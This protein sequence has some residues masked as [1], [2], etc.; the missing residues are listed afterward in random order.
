MILDTLSHELDI[1]DQW[2]GL[3]RLRQDY[4]PTPY[5]RKTPDHQHIPLLSITESAADYLADSHWAMPELPD[6]PPRTSPLTE[7]ALEYD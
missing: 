7:A 3:R 1:R 2:L 4:T 6:I 5:S